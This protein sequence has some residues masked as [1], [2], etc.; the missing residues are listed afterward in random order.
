[1]K[2]KIS[3][4][5]KISWPQCCV[6]CCGEATK[7]DEEFPYCD[8]CYTK[9]ERLRRWKDN[10]WGISLVFGFIGMVVSIIGTILEQ[11]LHTSIIVVAVTSGFVFMG[12][13]YV[14]I[15]L[16]LLPFQL[17]LHS[18]L[19]RPGVK[20]LKSKQ[21]GVMRLKISNPEYADKFQR[22]NQ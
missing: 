10:V 7:K 22:V 1:M 13:V 15:R 14:I 21:P 5:T 20:I 11:G 17:I 12:I 8:E 18:K 19:A 16:L 9:V 3:T 2:V 4:A 6:L